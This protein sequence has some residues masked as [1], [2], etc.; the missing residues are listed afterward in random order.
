[1]RPRDFL[2][3]VFKIF[4]KVIDVSKIRAVSN[5]NHPQRKPRY[6]HFLMTR[7][8]ERG[9]CRTADGFLFYQSPQAAAPKRKYPE[10]KERCMPIAMRMLDIVEAELTATL[11][12]SLDYL[13]AVPQKREFD[14]YCKLQRLL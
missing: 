7:S 1:M 13:S 10:R 5:L 6:L 14:G 9:G 11:R 4:C 8:A 3:E 2:V 12:S